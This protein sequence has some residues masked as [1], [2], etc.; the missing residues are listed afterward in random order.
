MSILNAPIAGGTVKGTAAADTITG[1]A[2]A[3]ILWGMGGNDVINA[4]DGDDVIEGD[5]TITVAQQVASTGFAI[6][7]NLLLTT[8]TSKLP[9][10]TS[11]GVLPSGQTV[12][13]LRNTSDVAETVVFQSAS[14][15]NGAYGPV[16]YVIPPHSDLTVTSTNPSVHKLFF[17]GK[18]VDV[19][20]PGNQAYSDSTI[21]NTGVDGNDILNGGNGNDTLNGGGGDDILIGGT[22]ADRLNGGTGADTADYSASTAGVIVNLTAG[23]GVGGDAQGDTL[24][25]VENLIGSKFNDTLIGDA[26]ANAFT[27][28]DG[29]DTISYANAT[30][31]VAFTQQATDGSGIGGQYINSAAGGFAGNANGD[32]YSG[33]EI[34]VGSAFADRIGGSDTAETYYL[35]AGDDVYDNVYTKNVVDTV[36]GEAGN[37]TMWTGGGDDVLSGGDGNDNLYGETGNDLIKGDAGLDTID[38][39]DG[40]DRVIGGA[41]ADTLVGSAGNDTADYS[42]SAAAV[43]VNLT[44]GTGLGGDAQGDTLASIENLTGSKFNDVLTGNA[45]ANILDGGDGDDRFVGS[46][47]GDTLLGGAGN[48]TADYSTSTAAV[49]VNLTAGTGL[50]GTAQ[51]DTLSSIENVTGSKFNDV[52]TGNAGAN[53]LDGG[54]GDDRFVGSAGGDTLLGGAGN[55]TA[56]YSTSTAAVTVNLTAGTGLGGTAQGDTLSSI[57]NVTGSKFNDVL[58]GA[59]GSNILVGGAGDD[60]LSGAG[61]ADQLIGG[62][63]NDTADYKVSSFAVVVNLATGV[64]LGGDA[65]GDTLNSIENLNGSIFDDVLTGDAGVNILS[66][67]AGNDLLV[68]GK[69][70]DVLN[71]G[72]GL[73]TADYSESAGCIVADMVAGK[74]TSHGGEVDQVTSIETIIGTKWADKFFGD[75]Y[76]NIFIAGAGNDHFFGS[77]GGDKFDGGEGKDWAD[78]SK[79]PSAVNVNL[80]TGLG[81]N[82]QAQGDTYV[83]IENIRGGLGDDIL[84]GD[85]SANVIYGAAG[86]DRIEGNGGNDMIYTGGGYDY[87]DGGAGIDT[88]SYAESWDKVTVNL[89]TGINQYGEASRDTLINVENLIGSKFDDN[90][91]GDAGVNVLKG[92]GGDDTLRGAGGDDV[93]IGGVGKDAMYGDAGVDLVSYANSKTGV[94]FSLA[95]GGILNADTNQDGVQ[96]TVI[97]LPDCDE[98]LTNGLG[99]NVVDTGYTAIN[100]V[101]EATGDTYFGI[102]NILGSQWNDKISGDDLGNRINGGA[103]N[104]FID[105]AGGIDYILGATGNDTL[106]G[107]AAADVFIFD[108]GFGNDSI[109]DFW[110]GVGRTDRLWLTNTDLHNYA[111]VLAHTTD[112]AA[113]L[114]IS[115]NGGQDSI[116]LA[117]IHL[118]QLNADDFLF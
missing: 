80:L 77:G 32:T 55:D 103:G 118:P 85:N 94:T 93:L 104:D 20:A 17:E 64:A 45:G 15:G 30:A 72:D 70:N 74:V 51:G 46:A 61:G 52:L 56:D 11:M 12:W 63:G 106:K 117:G 91:T 10:L 95:T 2:A 19:K 114:V 59:S 35:G 79:A 29:I 87:V 75:T 83:S 71:G 1:S 14:N 116:T 7:S 41:G 5:G 111:D 57:E 31:G 107:G 73:D 90:I 3:D 66:G 42:T 36:Y 97:V 76:A 60:L 67:D 27:A 13:R 34:V 16:T 96:P 50:G 8:S 54:D 92:G 101:S 40:D 69:G 48:D 39:G 89:T 100:G 84:V 113:G 25:G 26:N 82:G 37:D 33:F 58:I 115:I 18:Q 102:E 109:T 53:I 110:A 9:Q 49:T 24:T 43:N 108:A 105:G 112:T 99:A 68:G 21:V 22:G 28:G 44:T 47:G 78:Y 86:A 4:G 81:E 6:Y 23:T 62:D 65:Q 38:G 98:D 88:V